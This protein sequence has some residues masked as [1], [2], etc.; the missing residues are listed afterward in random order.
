MRVEVK[1][2]SL[3]HEGY[4][5]VVVRDMDHEHY[6]SEIYYMDEII[7]SSFPWETLEAAEQE[8]VDYFTHLRK[9][10]STGIR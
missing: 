8:A 7:Y 5:L 1:K 3:S 6:V 2:R 10:P 9:A 4:V